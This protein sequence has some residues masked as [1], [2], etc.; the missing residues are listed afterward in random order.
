MSAINFTEAKLQQVIT[1]HV[2]NRSREEGFMLSEHPS[3]VPPDTLPY[4]LQYFLTA[5]KGDEV[6]E[7]THPVQ[8]HQND[9]FAVAEQVFNANSSFMEQS[10]HLA[11]LL[12]EYSSHPKVISG[13][14]NVALFDEVPWAGKTLQAIGIFKSEKQLPYL[15]M[16]SGDARFSIH[17]DLGF[18]IDK[19]DKACIIFNT[20]KIDGYRVLI[21]DHANKADEAKYW[22]TDFLKVKPVANE[23]HQTQQFMNMTR[24]F[25]TQ[26][27]EQEFPITKA[28][29]IDLLNRSVQ[30]FKSHDSFEKKDFESSVLQEEG[31][32]QSFRQFDSG[33]RQQNQLELMDTFDISMPAVKKQARIFKSVLKLD[34]NFHIYIHGNRDLIEQGVDANGR[35]FYKLYFDQEF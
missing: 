8:L 1:H 3:N 17:H 15:K 12:Y 23:F 19:I 32:I 14:L 9:V 28:D 33:Y 30:Y 31:I 5:L 35:K 26:K 29:K 7:F 18:T 2:G 16:E 13:E 11:R 6:F 22:K 27:M 4:L 21:A 25:V 20:Q 34:K 10:Q 24:D